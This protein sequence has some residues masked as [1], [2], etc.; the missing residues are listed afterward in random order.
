VHLNDKAAAPV[1]G[2]GAPEKPGL[3]DGGKWDGV[4]A[5]SSGL[6]LSFPPDL[7]KYKLTFTKPGT[8]EYLCTVH[9]DMKGTVTVG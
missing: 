4:A 1:G 9:P 5:H 6:V 7:Y 3:F 2:P 8:F